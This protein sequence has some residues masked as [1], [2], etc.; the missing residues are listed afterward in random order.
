[1]VPSAVIAS[2]TTTHRSAMC[3][4]SSM[5][6]LMSSSLKSRLISSASAV[7]VWRTNRREIAE[8]LVDFASAPTWAPTGSAVRACRRV[9]TPASIRSITTWVSR[10]SAAKCA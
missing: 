9:A 7:S 6:T 10:S 1:L 2:A 4:P 3:S 5:S 8:R